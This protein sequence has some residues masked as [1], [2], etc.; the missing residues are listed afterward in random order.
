MCQQQVW[1]KM[2]KKRKKPNA[3]IKKKE[4]AKN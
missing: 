3:G 1:G 4:I 2:N